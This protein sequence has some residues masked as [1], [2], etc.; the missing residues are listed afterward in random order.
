M[1]VDVKPPPPRERANLEHSN[2]IDDDDLQ[3]AL[4]KQRREKL[5]KKS[6][7]QRKPEDIAAE[8]KSLEEFDKQD[9][10]TKEGGL[11]FD[12]TSEF[13]RTVQLAPQ[14]EAF[15]SK[16]KSEPLS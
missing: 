2:F 13:I 4:A 16:V 9:D 12:D 14:Q 5:K 8:I 6:S 11:E 15:E 7:R 1:E 3:I 10:K